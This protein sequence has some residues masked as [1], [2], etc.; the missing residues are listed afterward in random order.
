MEELADQIVAFALDQADDIATLDAPW[1]EAWAS[2]LVAMARESLGSDGP[3]LVVE[4]LVS[5]GGHRAATVLVAIRAIT[6]DLVDHVDIASLG[7]I[8]P[9]TEVIGTS[10]CGAAFEIRNRRGSSLVFRFVDS[11]EVEH[12]LVLDVIPG[13][14]EHLGEVHI[15][16]GD[17]FDV[18]E[19]DDAELEVVAV[20]TGIAADRVADALA[21]T[22]RP[23]PSAVINGQLLV[24]RLTPL[25]DMALRAPEPVVDDVQ[26]APDLDPDDARFALDLFDRAVG[27]ST[28]AAGDLRCSLTLVAERLRA[29]AR[30]DDPLAVWLAASVGPVDLDET[31]DA[32]VVAALAATI[33]PRRLEPLDP[34]QRDATVV[35][36]WADWL[37]A[38]IEL[39]RE[40]VGTPVDPSGLVD[41]VNRCPEVSTSVPD[42]DRPRLEWAFA[43]MT[44]PWG[45]LGVVDD[46]A[47]S[48]LGAALIPDAVHI[49]WAGSSP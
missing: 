33:A 6:R 14:P 26:P 20:P 12:L 18:L 5:V 48:E 39:C 1:A 3:D 40:G 46:E 24:A 49:A 30:D 23:R 35:L 36:E 2:D 8:P 37:G 19:E 9:W 34:S 45:Q 32:I 41:R 4:R 42:G 38:L 25:T 13:P 47:L 28:T 10:E 7:E 16:A 17:L 31:D 43:V 27:R 11:A 44:E 22:D 21:A 29:A 15:A